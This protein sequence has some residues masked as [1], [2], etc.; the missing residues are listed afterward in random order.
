MHYSLERLPAFT[1]STHHREIYSSLVRRHAR[2]LHR[3]YAVLPD[4]PSV[5]P[6]GAT[7]VTS[8]LARKAPD[9]LRFGTIAANAIAVG[10]LFSG[11][12]WWQQIRVASQI[13][14]DRAMA[15]AR[16]AKETTNDR[17]I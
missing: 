7:V 11:I 17:H 6:F 16:A 4:G 2:S 5:W 12:T 8:K 9:D 3:M 10:L 14:R 1:G 15:T 13:A